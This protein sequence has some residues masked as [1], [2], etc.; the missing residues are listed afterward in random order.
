M[1]ELKKKTKNTFDHGT[2][3]E[4]VDYYAEKSLT[5]TSVQRMQGIANCVKRNLKKRGISG[6]LNVADIGCNAGIMSLIWAREGHS[7]YGLDVNAA[8]LEIAKQRANQENLN[9][10]FQLGSATELPWENESMDVCIAPELL[11]HVADWETCLKEFVRI[12]KP[13]GVLF[14]ST[15]NKLCPIQEEF[16]LPL[17]SWYPSLLKHRFENLARTTRPEIAGYATYPAVNW[18]SFYQ[19]RREFLKM[20]M[21]SFDRFDIMDTEQKST[22]QRYIIHTVISNSVLRWLGHVASPGLSMLAIKK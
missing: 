21:D 16:T 19:L 14:V 18:F 1:K 8:L 15:T 5:A 17:Y 4:F 12:L 6:C 7:V 13:S 3:Q 20:G 11:E 10:D 9:I 2:R 22:Y